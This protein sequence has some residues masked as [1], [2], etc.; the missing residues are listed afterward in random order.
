VCTTRNGSCTVFDPLV[1]AT[2]IRWNGGARQGFLP[3]DQ[4]CICV[5]YLLIDGPE[6]PTTT[7]PGRPLTTAVRRHQGVWLSDG[8]G[9]RTKTQQSERERTPVRKRDGERETEKKSD[10]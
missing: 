1:S 9:E 4:N 3:I 10:K 7:H 8:L 2:V 6:L 5:F